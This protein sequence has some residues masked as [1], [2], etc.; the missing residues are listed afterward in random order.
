MYPR[1]F[2]S[3][4][5]KNPK[6]QAERRVYEALAASDRRGFVYYEWRKDYE[7]IELD[8]ALWIEGLD[9]IALQV[10]GGRYVLTDGD[11]FLKA[12]DGPLTVRSCPLDETKLAA[13]DLHDDIEERAATS[14]NP[15]VIPVLLFPD[16]APDPAIEQLARRKGVH[17][18]WRTADLMAD[19]AA[20]IRS[21]RVSDRLTMNRVVREVEAVTDGLIRLDVPA[22]EETGVKVEGPSTLCLWVGG[23]SLIQVRAQE[24]RLRLRTV[25][26]LERSDR[27]VA[28]VDTEGSFPA[29]GQF[30]YRFDG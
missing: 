27:E 16:M 20:I 29:T 10:K 19:L 9:R 25:S 14:Y 23:V 28:R 17:V 7:H 5:R 24:T 1:A 3:G 15:F 2:P 4:R 18:V 6:R 26:G 11:W 13:L 21:R 8:F 30:P 22:E 12:R